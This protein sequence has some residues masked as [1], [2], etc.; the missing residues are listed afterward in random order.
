[1]LVGKGEWRGVL[2]FQWGV[3]DY[4]IEGVC[5]CVDACMCLFIFIRIAVS[6]MGAWDYKM[7]W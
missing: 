3:D 2:I 4:K 6:C 7:F 1:M 5:I